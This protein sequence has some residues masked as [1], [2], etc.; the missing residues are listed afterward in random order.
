MTRTGD[1]EEEEQNPDAESLFKKIIEYEKFYTIFTEFLREAEIKYEEMDKR[2]KDIIKEIG[3]LIVL[4]GEEESTKATD[5]FGLF[6]NFARDFCNCYK[7]VL[8]SE[9]IKQEQ[10]LKKQ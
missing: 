1:E 7:N 8:L 10:E 3:D 5:F 2:V 6:Y 4:F 9:K